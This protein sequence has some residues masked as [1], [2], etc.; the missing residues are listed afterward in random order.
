M[1]GWRVAAMVLVV[2]SAL[3]SL[4]P[5]STLFHAWVANEERREWIKVWSSVVLFL[6]LGVVIYA[7][8]EDLSQIS[9]LT[10]Y[11]RWKLVLESLLFLAVLAI[12]IV[13]VHGRRKFKHNLLLGPYLYLLYLPA[14]IVEAL[15]Y[16][17]LMYALSI[18]FIGLCTADFL[19]KWFSDRISRLLQH[20]HAPLTVA[21]LCLCIA[22]AI[23]LFV[24]K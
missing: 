12:W 23:Q 1:L 17:A 6:T 9:W 10:Q 11:T 8:I 14:L 16:T 21:V 22:N 3:L 2:V 7:K 20:Q 18:L 19:S 24:L 13:R 15:H 5:V 4:G